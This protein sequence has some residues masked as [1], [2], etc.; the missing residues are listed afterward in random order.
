MTDNSS[1]LAES[2]RRVFYDLRPGKQIERRILL[3][4]FQSLINTGIPLRDAIYLGFG[5]IFFYDFAMFYR[6]LGFRKMISLE[7]DLRIKKRIEYNKPFHNIEVIFQSA[8]EYI[9]SLDRDATHVVWL[10]YDYT[11]SQN[12]LSDVL[13]V[14]ASLAPGSILLITVDAKAPKLHR[15]LAAFR[16]FIR[17]NAD[18]FLTDR[19]TDD[20][21]MP[22][23][24]AEISR[25]VLGVAVG[26]GLIARP[27]VEFAPLFSFLYDD[28][29]PMY[30]FGGMI[31]DKPLKR[32]LST[33]TEP[34]FRKNLSDDIFRIDVPRLTRKERAALDQSLPTGKDPFGADFG[35]TE[36]EKVQY[37]RVYRYFPSY[38]ESL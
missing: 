25:D 27:S 5:S 30:T 15:T 19:H 1:I 34:Y 16:A 33:C 20:I 17:N 38:V 37:G 35:I 18:G 23:H 4:A 6:Y 9:P 31:V 13:N 11:V 24:L 26:K 28:S 3:D 12:L 32:K 29:R 8:T 21:L 7:Q 2:Y 22:G 10:D 36:E 14:T